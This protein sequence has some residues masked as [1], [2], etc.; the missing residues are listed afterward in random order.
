MADL[1]NPRYNGS[2]RYERGLDGQ[3]RTNKNSR[4]PNPSPSFPS[5]K[6]TTSD[7]K[8]GSST[9]Q[10]D[11]FRPQLR[12]GGLI[13]AAT[14]LGLPQQMRAILEAGDLCQKTDYPILC[15]T[16]VKSTVNAE[17]ATQS[18]INYLILQTR[19]AKTSSSK[20]KAD[21]SLKDVCNE[22]YE[23]ALSNLMTSLQNLKSHDKPSLQT[24]LS[25]VISDLETCKDTFE[26]SNAKVPFENI[27]RQLEQ[28]ASNSLAL[29]AGLH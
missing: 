20:A 4:F 9:I 3:Q 26:E 18:A 21:K 2:H 14:T 24:N 19:D 5:S 25:A 10:S 7:I 27:I 23:D 29:A 6:N 17:K 22:M 13:A 28:M 15:R 1:R 11:G 16:M 8:I 12:P